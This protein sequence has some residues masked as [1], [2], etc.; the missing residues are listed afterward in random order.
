MM[1]D[2][3]LYDLLDKYSKGE[4]SHEQS[5]GVK[6][7]MMTDEEF[8]HKAEEH[9]KVIQSIRLF[10][11]REAVRRT[12]SEISLENPPALTGTVI[13]STNGIRSWM[14]YWP[15]AAAAAC[16]VLIS[17][18]GTLLVTQVHEKEQT[19][20]FIEA[21][22]KVEQK[23]NLIINKMAT[24]KEEKVTPPK[25]KVQPGRY[26]G[27]GFLV[28]SNGYIITSHHVVKGADSVYVENE[29][30]GTLKTS[31]VYSDAANDVSVLR[32]E[33]PEVKVGKLPY[34]ISATEANLGEDVFTLGFPR[35]DIV[36]GEGSISALSGYGQ[37]PNSYQVSVPV[38]PGNS[39]G[40]LFNSKGDLVGIISGLQT[41]TSG[42]AFAIKSSI[43]L[44][45]LKNMPEDSVHNP[46]VLPKYN[47]MRN[48][49]KVA[50]VNRW[51]DNV[52]IVRVYNNK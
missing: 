6:K 17:V 50:Q 29:V 10:G 35:E 27:T 52:F 22:R 5:L 47:S 12:L 20:R 34:T 15:A 14:K 7:K 31:V 49:N 24:P 45:V 42:A 32:I 8:R 2:Q 25:P 43:L 36:F 51:K 4:L 19:A 46:V 26:A 38:N 13:K 41:E 9:L 11:R 30:L 16:V 1:D 18:L 39:G 3:E 28:S 33:N 23:Q 37:N 21:V 48:L 44:D 40:P